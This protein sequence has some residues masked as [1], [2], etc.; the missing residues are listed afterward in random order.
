MVSIGADRV[1]GTELCAY[2][3]RHRAALAVPVSAHTQ[4]T[5]SHAHIQADVPVPKPWLCGV[6]EA[7]PTSV[8]PR[9]FMACNIIICGCDLFRSI[10][11]C[12]HSSVPVRAHTHVSHNTPTEHSTLYCSA[13][14]RVSVCTNTL[15]TQAAA[16]P[17]TCLEHSQVIRATRQQ[18]EAQASIQPGQGAQSTPVCSDTGI[19]PLSSHTGVALPTPPHPP[20][21]HMR[22]GGFVPLC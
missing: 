14:S 7:M 16:I 3:P 17:G 15:Y 10:P 19:Y 20:F 8:P 6:W 2:A 22:A 18:S 11:S 4:L 1:H 13:C 21:S 9:R 5:R 12:A